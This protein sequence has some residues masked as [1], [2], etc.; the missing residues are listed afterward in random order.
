MAGLN[1]YYFKE[2]HDFDYGD[3]WRL[4][5]QLEWA[6]LRGPQPDLTKPYVAC[7]GAAHTFGRFASCTYAAQLPLQ[8]ANMGVG[9]AV[10]ATYLNE[11]WLSVLNAAAAVVM[12]VVSARGAMID[13]WSLEKNAAGYQASWVVGKESDQGI[14]ASDM[15]EKMLHKEPAKFELSLAQARMSYLRDFALLLSS[16][17]PPVILLWIG[18]RPP[19]Y[20]TERMD[21]YRGVLKRFPHM[22]TPAM[23]T[24]MQP[25]AQKSLVV[26][27]EE[28]KQ[29]YPDDPTHTR[30]AE[31]LSPL[32][33]ELLPASL[34]GT[35]DV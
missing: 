26:V 6:W 21:G 32:I 9:G 17:I 11:N 5:G 12:P 13:A 29:Y 35:A 20:D 27:T 24:A 16:I 23:W 2:D 28:G 18:P 7:P 30:I 10:P 31:Q 33:W 19:E 25:L 3:P 4:Q 8:G 14:F 1:W 15:W 22:V 34:K